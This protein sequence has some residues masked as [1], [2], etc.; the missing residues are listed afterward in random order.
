M[1]GLPPLWITFVTLF[2]LQ[3]QHYNYSKNQRHSSSKICILYKYNSCYLR[4]MTVS[5]NDNTFLILLY[6]VCQ[7][8]CFS[9]DSVMVARIVSLHPIRFHLNVVKLIDSGICNSPFQKRMLSLHSKR[10]HL[11][12]VKLI[13]SGICTSLFHKRILSLHP[14]RFHLDNLRLIDSGICISL[15]QKR[16]HCSV[17]LIKGT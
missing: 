17:F 16:M 6:C 10:F 15:F 7:S 9:A 4:A 12:I 13:D 1:P 14:K 11:S 5:S 3:K 2:D 8:V